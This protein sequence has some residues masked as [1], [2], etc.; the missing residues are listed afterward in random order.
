MTAP[1][2]MTSATAKPS[3]P[4]GRA[5]RIRA[6]A[7]QDR[8][9]RAAE[10]ELAK[11][12]LALDRQKHAAK[13]AEKQERRH[14]RTIARKKRA[15]AVNKAIPTIGRRIMIGGPIASPMTVA[16][17]GQIL[18]AV[19][20]LGW[21]VWAAVIFAA[22]WE[23]TTA[24]AGWMHH[25]ARQAGDRGSLFRAA[26]W[27]FAASAG[28]MNYWHALDH[29][30]VTHPTPKAVSYGAMSLV[31]IGL[32]E[33]YSSLIHRKAL[34]ARGLVPAVRPRF[35]FARWARYPRITWTAWSLSIHDQISTVEEAWGAAVIER[36]AKK[37]RKGQAD[38]NQ[39]RIQELALET[40]TKSAGQV[41][42]KSV[43]Y[44]SD[45]EA[46][47]DAGQ[48]T[49][50]PLPQATPAPVT[51]ATGQATP[52][53]LTQGTGE[54]VTSRAAEVTR[55]TSAK[56]PS[57]AAAKSRRSDDELKIELDKIVA[58]H[59][60]THPGEEIKVQPVAKQLGIGRDRARTLLDQMNVRPIRRE[61]TG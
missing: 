39:V 8:L 42:S 58:E 23:L 29:N 56:S 20:V 14:A 61:A 13:M 28:A 51:Q 10:L 45:P 24:F 36:R 50:K 31:G 15:A 60:R 19:H 25:Q 32:W 12:Q 7:E 34:R 9:D 2:W 57:K 27:L 6:R 1:D 41:T 21:P 54:P 17:I 4:D 30:S 3:S 53:E 52:A 38:P 11:G 22:S 47:P 49:A 37:A 44:A 40:L 18:F 46:Q 55:K 26:T 59:Y 35:G 5:E 48:V 16:W 33:L 43:T